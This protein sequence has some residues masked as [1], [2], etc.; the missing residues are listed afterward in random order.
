MHELDKFADFF[1]S[2]STYAQFK[3]LAATQLIP[4]QLDEFN[5]Y[6]NKIITNMPLDLLRIPL[7]STKQDKSLTVLAKD[8]DAFEAKETTTSSID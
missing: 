7:Q 5:Q 3:I 8:I 4:E 2:T 6:Q 1:E